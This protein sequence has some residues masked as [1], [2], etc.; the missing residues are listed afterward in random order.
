MRALINSLLIIISII[1]K[2]KSISEFKAIK[3]D[4]GNILVIN[5]KGI[6]KYDK[7]LNLYSI[8]NFD[9]SLHISATE[10]ILLFLLIY[11]SFFSY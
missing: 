6:Y 10:K 11:L 8:Y 7:N 9:S 5:Q 2:I 3:I 1:Y 4:N